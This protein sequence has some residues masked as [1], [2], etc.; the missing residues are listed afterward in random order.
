LL[1]TITSKIAAAHAWRGAE[2]SAELL[3][4]KALAQADRLHNQHPAYLAVRNE[5]GWAICRNGR[6]EEAE[7]MLRQVL[8]GRENVL[9]AEHADTLDTRHKF[10]W[11]VG[12][13]GNWEAA[14]TQLREVLE[15]RTHLLGAEHPDTLHTRCCLAWAAVERGRLAEAETEYREL[16]AVRSRVLG[17]DHAETWDTLHS[18]AEAFVHYGRYRDAEILLRKIIA[19]RPRVLGELDSKYP[20]TLDNRPHYWLACAL[21]GQRRHRPAN[22]EFRRLLADQVRTLGPDHPAT[23][24]TS[25][26]LQSRHQSVTIPKIEVV[27]PKNVS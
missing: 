19:A 17:E 18:L 1:L 25:E 7:R 13:R 27:A 4:N 26:Q 22:K 14:E 20:E 15:A 9:G 6:F 11:V 12:K 21:R 24:A 3:A 23:V 5:L 16:F 2:S 10:A 8:D